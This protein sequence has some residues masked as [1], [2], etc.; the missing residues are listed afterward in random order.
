MS[1]NRLFV[2]MLAFVAIAWA[3]RFAAMLLSN[4]PQQK[5]EAHVERGNYQE[6]AEI[7]QRLAA[8]E[9][10]PFK[11]LSY[12]HSLAHCWVQLERHE[13]AVAACGNAIADLEQMLAEDRCPLAPVDAM[14]ML[15]RLYKLRSI[16]HERLNN[17]DAAR[18]DDARARRINA[19]FQDR[20]E[21]FDQFEKELDRVIRESPPDEIERSVQGLRH[22]E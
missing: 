7:Y 5:A 8:A 6:A 14:D 17:L 1:R 13:E 21:R 2:L 4:H 11:R 18:N 19:D 12:H 20:V 16:S 15:A 3:I 9:S 22:P 10:E